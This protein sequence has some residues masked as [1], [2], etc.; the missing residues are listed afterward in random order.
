MSTIPAACAPNTTPLDPEARK[1][2]DFWFGELNEEGKAPP[3]QVTRW[4][5]KD[6]AFDEEIRSAFG[7]LHR[8]V[9]AGEREAWLGNPE[10]RLAYVVVL[11]QFSRNMFRGS[12]EMFAHDTRALAAALGAIDLGMDHL[13]PVAMR[14]FFYLPLMHSEELEVQER[15]MKLYQAMDPAGQGNDFAR[16]HRNIV[17]RFGHFPHRNALLGR[18][19]SVEEE[20]FLQESGSSF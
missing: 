6:P 14:S 12:G 17:A 2:L 10:E 19:S 20:I 18:A 8:A 15:C 7:A 13:L 4:F 5:K 9:A 1:V 3:E 11:D 16:Q